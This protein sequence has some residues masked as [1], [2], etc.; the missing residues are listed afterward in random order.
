MSIKWPTACSQVLCLPSL[1]RIRN[2]PYDWALVFLSVIKSLTWHISKYL[3]GWRLKIKTMTRTAGTVG[4][5]PPFMLRDTP[6]THSGL[7]MG[8]ASSGPVAI[9]GGPSWKW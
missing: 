6:Q 3:R 4:S 7:Q 5:Q 2:S 8:E 9:I 1:L